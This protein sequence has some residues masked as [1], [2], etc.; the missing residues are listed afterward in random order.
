[1]SL[2]V[3]VAAPFKQAGADRVREN[4]FVVA[5]SLDRDWMSPDQ[6][7]RVIDIA[8]GEGLL[9]RDG[10]AVVAAFDPG[11][12]SVPDG[13]DPDPSIFQERSPFERVLDRLVDAG[14]EK[15]TAVAEINALQDELAITVEAAAVVVARRRGVEVEDVATAAIDGLRRDEVAAD[16]T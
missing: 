14:L 13:F 4:E 9:R 15:Q 5:L 12:V 16:N 11:S 2:R 10:D 6:A 1:M 7:K 3:V 8:T